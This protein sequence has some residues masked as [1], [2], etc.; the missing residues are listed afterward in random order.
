METVGCGESATLDLSPR[1]I[2]C[3]ILGDF[4]ILPGLDEDA[5]LV[6]V[7]HNL[8]LQ[9]LTFYGCLVFCQ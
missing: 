1:A 8:A 3:F 7:A 5:D 9:F 4:L 2:N 6:L